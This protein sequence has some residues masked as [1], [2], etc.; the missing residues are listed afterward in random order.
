MKK[1]LLDILVCPSCLP[2]E[3]TLDLS[4]EQAGADDIISGYLTCGG[5]GR[6]YEIKQGIANL[7][8]GGAPSPSF[9]QSR[10]EEMAVVSSYLWSHYADLFGDPEAH[11]AYTA[12]AAAM[13]DQSAAPP[14]LDVGC[15]VGRFTFEL[16][17]KTKGENFCVGIDRSAAFI[18]AARKLASEG[19]LS[20]SLKTEGRLTEEKKITIPKKWKKADVEFIVGDALALPFSRQ[21]FSLAASLNLLDKVSKPLLHLKEIN[22]VAKNSRARLLLADP[23]SWSL[24]SALEEDW[25][26]GKKQGPYSGA[27]FRGKSELTGTILR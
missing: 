6:R 22:R 2:L 19:S 27:G 21:S 4:A 24:E 20:F 11:G 7:L 13:G 5:C 12:W 16:A 9:S 25:P 8:P 17:G 18:S 26:G 15:A 10:Y 1:K 23:F 14:A 3:K